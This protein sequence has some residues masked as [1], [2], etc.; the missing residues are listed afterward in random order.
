MF[1]SNIVQ[2][3][4]LLMIFIF[5][6]DCFTFSWA[7]RQY[8][9]CFILFGSSFNTVRYYKGNEEYQAQAVPRDFKAVAKV[10]DRAGTQLQLRNTRLLL[11]NGRTCLVY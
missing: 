8:G 3:K 5:V 10:L 11:R 7:L 4:L 9:F 1:P 6:Y 2:M